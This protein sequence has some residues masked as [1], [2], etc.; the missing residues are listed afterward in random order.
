MSKFGAWMIKKLTPF[1]PKPEHPFNLNNE[2]VMTYA[3]WQFS[4]A[5]RTLRFYMPA[6]TPQDMFEDKVVLDLGC[7]E[8]GKTVY[9]ASLGAK[10]VGGVECFPDYEDRANA[11][12]AKKGL[13]DRFHFQLGDATDLPFQEGTFDTVIMNDF[14]E[15]VSRPEEAL[16]EALRVLKEDGAIYANFPPYYHPYG[17]HLSDAIG[18]PW[19]HKIFSEDSMIRAYTDLVKDLPDGGSRIR[20]RF[21]YDENGKAYISY[22][23]KMTIKRFEGILDDLHIVPTTYELSPLRP[24]LSKLAG[25]ALFR[26]SLNSMVTCVIRKGRAE[27]T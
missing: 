16:R 1:F 25:T 7:G 11:F 23:N 26:E 8:A 5:E 12:A 10:P 14:I 13:A 17:A 24:W 6:Y 4:Q 15:H 18:I 9:Y 21:S 3:D 22:I 19:I 20:F 2:G 27:I